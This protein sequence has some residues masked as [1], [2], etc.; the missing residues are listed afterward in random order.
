MGMS[1]AERQRRY[2]DRHLNGIEGECQRVNLIASIEAKTALER[3]AH[4]HSI[5]QRQALER[6]LHEAQSR[7]LDRLSGDQANRFYD[8]QLTEA[9]LQRNSQEQQLPRNDHRTPATR[10]S[11]PAPQ[12]K[13]P[14]PADTAERNRRIIEL[15]NSTPRPS[16]VEIGKR[17]DCSEAAVRRL[18][19]KLAA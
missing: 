3:L 17:C 4:F 8:R 12:P 6:A 2:R 7:I 5:T 10:N 1:N 18:L 9:A 19:K 15:A 11:A 14:A 13:Q 16:N